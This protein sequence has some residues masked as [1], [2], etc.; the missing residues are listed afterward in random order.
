MPSLSALP[1]PGTKVYVGVNSP[2]FSSKPETSS[3]AELGRIPWKLLQLA[4]A[5]FCSTLLNFPGHTGLLNRSGAVTQGTALDSTS[6]TLSTVLGIAQATASSRSAQSPAVPDS[7]FASPDG[8][9]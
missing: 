6:K 9:R 8:C 7:T 4:N 2:A 3:L 5:T 1:K